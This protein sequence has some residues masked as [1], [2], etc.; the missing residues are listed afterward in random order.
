[1]RI[2][3]IAD[4]HGNREAFDAVLHALEREEIDRIA[5]LGDLVGYGAD[6]GYCVERAAGLIAQGAVAVMGNHDAAALAGGAPGF[7]DCAREAIVWT[8][9]KLNDAHLAVLAGLPMTAVEGERLYV[10]ASAADPGAWRYVA[11]A[12]EAERAL[13]ATPQRVVLCGHHHR[14]AIYC[15][16]PDQGALGFTPA[17]DAPIPLLARRRWLAVIGAC[18]QPRDENPAAPYAVLDEGTRSLRLRRAPYDVA[19]AARKIE[20]AGLPH[21]LAARLFLGR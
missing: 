14:P 21:M 13:A 19:T 7:N 6:P 4:V 16:S 3:L 11:D 12:A 8:R 5:L 1:M 17:T 20:A 18:G 2:A 10:H 15:Q 9:G